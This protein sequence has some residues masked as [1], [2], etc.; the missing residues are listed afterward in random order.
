MPKFS[1]VV[2]LTIAALVGCSQRE[3][4]T[5]K[6]QAAAVAPANGYTAARPPTGEAPVVSHAPLTLVPAAATATPAK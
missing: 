1:H 6:E 4:P 3:E 2:L 5:T